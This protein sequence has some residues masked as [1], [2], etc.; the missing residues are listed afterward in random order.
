VEP[1]LLN[2]PSSHLVTNQFTADLA[3]KLVRMVKDLLFRTPRLTAGS[4]FILI[5]FFFHCHLEGV[6][7]E[8]SLAH[9]DAL[10]GL[11]LLFIIEK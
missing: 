8:R 10:V 11:A 2:C 7:P 9:R 3:C 4:F 1:Q 5:L 6:H